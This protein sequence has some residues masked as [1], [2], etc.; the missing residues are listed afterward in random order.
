MTSQQLSLSAGLK[1]IDHAPVA[2]KDLTRK[3]FLKIS[4]GAAALGIVGCD[5]GD[6]DG[7]GTATDAGTDSTSTTNAPTTDSTSS[8]SGNTT[9]DPGTTS[10]SSGVD[11]SGSSGS[12]GSGSGSESGSGSSSGGESSSST[13]VEDLCPSGA[14]DIDWPGNNNH[15][16]GPHAVMIDAAMLTPGTALTG[17]DI[18]GDSGHPHTIDLTGDDVD[19]LLAGGTI[20]VT[21]SFDNNHDHDVTIG[22]AAK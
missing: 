5:G 15:A 14:V 8:S 22:C 21:S 20:T 13:G 10:S 2:S 17:V 7:E 3:S 19:M 9:D 1:S 12:S 18:Q 4:M 11:D 16:N 6:D